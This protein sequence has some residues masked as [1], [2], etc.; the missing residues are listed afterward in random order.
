MLTT[1]GT[2]APYATLDPDEV[3]DAVWRLASGLE[4]EVVFDVLTQQR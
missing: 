1:P 2:P 3:A 4:E